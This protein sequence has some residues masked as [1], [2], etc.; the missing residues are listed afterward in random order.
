MEES[1]YGQSGG[2]DDK[3]AEQLDPVESG[4]L[5]RLDWLNLSTV[6]SSS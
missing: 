3:G 4:W 5:I 2:G 6:E 1:L